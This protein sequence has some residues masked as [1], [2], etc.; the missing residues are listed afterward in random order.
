MKIGWPTIFFL[1]S[2]LFQLFWVIP[3]IRVWGKRWYY[4]GM[5]G[6]IMSIVIYVE[7]PVYMLGI[8]AEVFQA[9]FIVSAVLS[10]GESW[11]KRSRNFFSYCP[12]FWGIKESFHYYEKHHISSV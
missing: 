11:C 4:V 8:A 7:Y 5:I 9:A 3:L 6:S 12:L 2:G 1:I 10:F